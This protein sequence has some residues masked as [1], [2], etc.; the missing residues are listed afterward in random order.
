MNAPDRTLHGSDLV[1]APV[2]D[3]RELAAWDMIRTLVGFDTTSRDSNL[4]L[5]H[6]VRDYLAGFGIASTL[7]FDDERRKANLYA[8]LPARDGNAT[9]PTALQDV[10]RCENVPGGAQPAYWDVTY[11]FRDREHRIQ[12][13]VEPGNTILVNERGEPRL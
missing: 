2:S 6:W 13:A 9:P 5:I 8:T 4:A 7:T 11:R 12:M 10:Q 1:V 3:A